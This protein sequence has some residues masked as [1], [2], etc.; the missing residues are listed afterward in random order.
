MRPATCDLQAAGTPPVAGPIHRTEELPIM[1]PSLAGRPAAVLCALIALTVLLAGCGTPSPPASR[2]TA[3]PSLAA[4]AP[5]A[6]AE[7]AARTSVAVEPPSAAE[8]FV[9]ARELRTKQAVFRA[10]KFDE[11]PGWR[12]DDLT[13][14]WS[15]MRESCKVLERRDVWRGLCAAVRDVRGDD[16]AAIRQFFEREFSLLSLA[17]PDASRE[18]D[19]TGYYEPLLAGQP[20]PGGAFIV[21][22]Y[23]TPNDLY[24]LDLR[25]VPAHQRRG[26]L[27]VRPAAGRTLVP[28]AAGSAGSYSLDLGAFSTDALDRRLRA[29]LQGT[30]ALPYHTREQIL[31]GARLDAPVL[32]WVDDP[33]ALYAMQVQGAGRIRLPDG[34][35]IRVNYAEQNGHPFKPLRL[36]SKAS[37][38]VVTRGGGNTPAGDEPEQ[39]ELLD[40]A[41]LDPDD[42]D[43][44]ASAEPGDP[45]TRGGRGG[46]AAWPTAAAAAPGSAAPAAASTTAQADALVRDLLPAA[47]RSPPG[48]AGAPAAASPRAAAAPARPGAAAPAP[49]RRSQALNTD[50]SYVFFRVATDQSARGGPVG[51][52]GVPL[53]AGRSVAVDPRSTPL[54]YPVYLSAAGPGLGSALQRLV[55]AQDAGGAIRGAVRADYFWGFGPDAGRQASRTKHRGRMWVLLPNAEAREIGARRVVTRGGGARAQAAEP[56]CLVP[57]ETYCAEGDED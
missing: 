8:V 51:A 45:L 15:A 21:P 57:D 46:A 14:A 34:K 50:P 32:A 25:Q 33:V 55:F 38:R 2:P 28:A 56:A 40:D 5:A 43:D 48:S 10:S 23:G 52:L 35:V 53:T 1:L 11:L 47:R 39:F 12:T 7:P 20:R 13:G 49:A 42:P 54:G 41:A 44:P 9:D 24:T 30:Q 16:N 31:A 36:A 19:V 18:G 37:Q 29:R 17:N 4:P 26:V 3:L 6:A 22:V 27:A